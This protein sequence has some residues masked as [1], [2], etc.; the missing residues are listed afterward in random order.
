M[1]R[2]LWGGP[3]CE[4]L[5]GRPSGASVHLVVWGR[6]VGRPDLSSGVMDRVGA[7]TSRLDE[8]RPGKS[9]LQ[10]PGER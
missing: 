2:C 10:N 4:T 6:G 9:I 7:K 5:Y 1:K 8:K 3:G